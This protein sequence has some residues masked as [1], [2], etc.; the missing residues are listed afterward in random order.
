MCDD[1]LGIGTTVTATISNTSGEFTVANGNG[2]TLFV[3][4]NVS[5]GDQVQ[6]R[7][8][9]RNDDTPVCITNGAE[10]KLR[11]DESS[12]SGGVTANPA[13]GLVK[14]DQDLNKNDWWRCIITE[15]EEQHIQARAYKKIPRRSSIDSGPLPE[16]PT[17][18]LNRLAN[19]KH[20][21]S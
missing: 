2:E 17:Q 15:I 3:Y 11:I 12:D 5:V 16:S 14:I 7:I 9:D 20:N 4:G 21:D 19:N 8:I 1:T 6:V 10:I 13:F 18:S